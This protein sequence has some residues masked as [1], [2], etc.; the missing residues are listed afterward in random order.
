MVKVL[1]KSALQ[2][3]YLNI[4]KAI[5][6]KPIANIKLNIKKLKAIALKSG[7]RQFFLILHIYSI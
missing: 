3:L 1:E 6:S 2:G 7:I 4:V 5:C